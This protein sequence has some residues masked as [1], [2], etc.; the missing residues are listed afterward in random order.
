MPTNVDATFDLR[1]P[2]VVMLLRD[3]LATLLQR[4]DRV[5]R[6]IGTPVKAGGQEIE[7]TTFE[8]PLREAMYDYGRNIF[9]LSLLISVITAGLLFLAVRRFIVSPI[10]DVAHNM[11]AFQE[12]PEDARRIITPSASVHELRSAEVALHDMQMR[13]AASLK[14]KERLAQLGGA[15]AKVSHDLRNMLTTATL[16]AD[17]LAASSDPVVA[18]A[19]PKLIGSLDRAINLCERT[20]VFGKAEEPAPKIEDMRLIEVVQDVVESE[21]LRTEGTLVSI[22]ADIP[23]G[24]RVSADREQLFRVIINLARNARQAIEKTGASGVV[25]IEARDGGADTV[26]TLSDTGPGLP[27]KALDHLFEPFS[28]GTRRDG[29]GLGLPIAAELVRGHGGRLE[30]ISSDNGGTTFSVAI[31]KLKTMIAAK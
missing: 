25:R 8:T 3:A 1:D 23:E 2:G 7:A 17:R 5:I 4:E 6:V 20:L 18:R 31:P 16:V 26:I 12:S 14:Q 29:T 19:A 13:V 28:G 11:T 10:R 21:L 15:V 30:L 22:E 9:Y 27:Q 24:L